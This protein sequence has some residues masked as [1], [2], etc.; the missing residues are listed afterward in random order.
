LAHLN[1]SDLSAFNKY[2]E[3]NWQLN[4]NQLV[5]GALIALM[6]VFDPGTAEK[7]IVSL[8]VLLLP[9]SMLYALTHKPKFPNFAVFLIFPFVFSRIIHLGFYNFAIGLAFFLFVI[10]YAL[11]HSDRPR[12]R[13]GGVLL[14]LLVATYFVHIM[15]AACA[16]LAVGTLAVARLIAALRRS[17]GWLSGVGRNS[18]T[19]LWI[20]TGMVAVVCVAM[21]FIILQS[22]A[23]L[24]LPNFES[25]WLVKQLARVASISVLVVFSP[26]DLFFAI[27]LNALL[28]CM[29]ILMLSKEIKE[30]RFRGTGQ[31]FGVLGIF[32]IVYM[33]IPKSM[34][35]P[36]RLLIYLYFLVILWL[37][38][39][40]VRRTL[41]VVLTSVCVIVAVGALAYRFPIYATLNAKLVEFASAASVLDRG[42]TLYAVR[43]QPTRELWAKWRSGEEIPPDLFE[44]VNVFLNAHG[45]L[46]AEAQL[47]NLANYQASLSYFPL[48]LRP[49]LKHGLTATPCCD[50]RTIG[51]ERAAKDAEAEPRLSLPYHGF[52]AY[53]AR[54]GG[55]IDYVLVWEVYEELAEQERGRLMLA[56]LE[57]DYDLVLVSEP[58]GL[59]RVY[60]RRS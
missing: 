49:A 33:M 12:P 3:S 53:A 24:E 40:E 16:V 39:L 13:H 26:H 46:A 37:G 18:S 59:M 27:L 41:Q 22:A 25:E 34:F 60:R 15:A 29:G 45:R 50:Q 8:Y 57:R 32:T 23:Y 31:L 47:V 19:T 30:R 54:T 58:N 51:S 56:E 10:G 43:E 17:R 9:I 52:A 35:L 4:T 55:Q 14:A 1:D 11:R 5:A 42:A 44:R 21:T 48:R 28:L 6:T 7:I 38:G 2:F 36:E 20:G